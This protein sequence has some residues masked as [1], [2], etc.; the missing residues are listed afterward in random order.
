MNLNDIRFRRYPLIG[1]HFSR[2]TGR[3]TER[4]ETQTNGHDIL[5]RCILSLSVS[6][7]K[8]IVRNINAAV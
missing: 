5:N 2:P 3:Q 8:M 1:C 7:V 4:T 6:D